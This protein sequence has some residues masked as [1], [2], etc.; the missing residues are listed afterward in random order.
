[1]LPREIPEILALHF[2][3]WFRRPGSPG[4]EVD[5]AS[6][7]SGYELILLRLRGGHSDRGRGRSHAPGWAVRGP[8]SIGSFVVYRGPSAPSGGGLR[9]HGTENPCS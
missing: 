6:Y 8:F 9:R 2:N 3:S 5:Q 7:Y 1:M 4:Q